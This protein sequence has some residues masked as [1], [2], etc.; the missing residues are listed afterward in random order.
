MSIPK[1]K[2]KALRKQ[3]GKTQDEIARLAGM[4]RSVYAKI[5]LGLRNPTL[6]QSI[7]IKKALD[8]HGDDIFLPYVVSK[9]NIGQEAV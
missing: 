1:E 4:S 3:S 6:P 5:E 9:R 8:Y 7:M 2:M